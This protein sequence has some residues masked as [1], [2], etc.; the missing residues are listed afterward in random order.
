MVVVDANLLLV[1]V[2]GDA[3]GSLALQ[4]FTDW[5]DNRVELHAPVLAQYEVANGLT[6]L[7]AAGTFPANQVETAWNDISVLPIVYHPLSHASR[8]I[9][10][11]LTLGRQNAYDASYIALAETIGA[12]LWTFDSPLYRNASG[13]GLP[14]R[15]LI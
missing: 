8:V 11:A 9:E 4:Q 6:R 2:S 15:L 7:I 5:L 12:E 3:R 1:L 13:R 10:I 14:V